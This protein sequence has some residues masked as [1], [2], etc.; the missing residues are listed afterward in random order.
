M[1]RLNAQGYKRVN[2]I[3]L[4]YRMCVV[5]ITDMGEYSH[6]RQNFWTGYQFMDICQKDANYIFKL[7]VAFEYFDL[8]DETFK[9]EEKC[10]CID[11]RK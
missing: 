6:W 11:C 7:D 2:E 10:N 1:K 9:L 5:E 8:E 3:A 4:K